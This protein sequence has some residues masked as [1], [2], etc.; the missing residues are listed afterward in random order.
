MPHP[1]QHPHSAFPDPHT[2][3]RFLLSLQETL[4]P[5]HGGSFSLGPAV[6]SP[7]FCPGQTTGPPPL[8]FTL[9]APL[10]SR[11][12]SASL[13]WNP[14]P[15]APQLLGDPET[16]LRPRCLSVLRGVRPA[17]IQDC[18]A[19][20]PVPRRLQTL[21]TPYPEAPLT[22]RKACAPVSGSDP[23]APL[24]VECSVAPSLRRRPLFL[25]A[26]LVSVPFLILET[27]AGSSDSHPGVP[28]GPLWEPCTP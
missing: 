7:T 14:V 1:Q 2:R 10:N 23:L 4:C 24:T 27:V 28:A 8:G 19:P 9:V 5:L 13:F 21:C 6:G 16:P 18:L 22:I 12:P 17:S 3:P 11:L 26:L 25:A 20:S 15:A